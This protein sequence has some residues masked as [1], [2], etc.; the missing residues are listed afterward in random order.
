[1]PVIDAHAHLGPCKVFDLNVSEDD[2]VKAMDR[3]NVEAAVVQPF[4][5]A[6][7]PRNVHD[8]IAKLAEKHPG[9]FFGL[10]SVNPHR[11]KEEY[12]AEVERC[13]KDLGFVAVKL[14]TIGHAVSPL[15]QDGE[16]VFATAERLKVPVMVHTGPG[17]PF[18]LPSLCLPKARAHPSL[19][20][21]LAHAGFGLFTGEAMVAAQ[22]CSNIFF[23]T[24]WVSG[25]DVPPLVETLGADRVMFGT[26]LPANI[27]LEMEKYK[28]IG[29]SQQALDMVLGGTAVK[30]YKLNV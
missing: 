23:E 30:V 2:L 22:E 14:H 29:L 13:V 21:I 3:F 17:V 8:R 18:A 16:M 7:N 5:G 27:P 25:L 6:P 26:D 4:P 10:A 24:S 12:V 19:P 15:S 20:I 28:H 11:P 9:R 1:M